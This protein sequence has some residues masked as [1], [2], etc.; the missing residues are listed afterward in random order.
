MSEAIQA[1]RPRSRR[2]LWGSGVA[3]AAILA[4]AATVT[5]LPR[6]PRITSSWPYQGWTARVTRRV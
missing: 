2:L 3:L 6:E 1:V 4:G 5:L